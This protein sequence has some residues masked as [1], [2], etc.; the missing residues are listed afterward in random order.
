[1]IS[2]GLLSLKTCLYWVT[3]FTLIDARTIVM[4]PHPMKIAFLLSYVCIASI[5]A[6]IITPAL[7]AIETTYGLAHGALE[8]VVSLFLLGYVLGQLF[9]GPLANRW[10]RIKALQTGLYLNL[11][12]I[13]LCLIAVTLD[14]FAWLLVGRFVS[15]FGAASGLACTFMLINEG[16]PK[17]AAKQTL[18]YVAISFT[19]GVGIAVTIGGV[20][21]QYVGWWACFWALLIHGAVMLYGTRHLVETRAKPEKIALTILAQQLFA[22][23]K[24][25]QLVVFSITMGFVSSLSYTFSAT[26]PIFTQATLQLSPSDYGYW[27]LL[28]TLAMLSSGLSCASL[29]KR[30]EL[31]TVGRF[32]LAALGGTLLLLAAFWWFSGHQVWVFFTCTA[33]LFFFSGW[34]FPFGSYY[35]TQALPDKASAAS[36]MSFLNMLTA[37]MAVIIIGYLSVSALTAFLISLCC[38]FFIVLALLW[39]YLCQRQPLRES[40]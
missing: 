31:L 38:L 36:M 24:S 22:T 15:A 4:S 9:Y 7:P 6:A 26:A 1:M 10:G 34:L 8:W 37:T 39:P 40:T 35:A 23:L 3:P 30:Y 11:F 19:L 21:T 28:N 5:S 25:R 14:S 27:N 29:L 17:P 2:P 32:S 18:S 13:A 20:L 12:G 33:L 16:L